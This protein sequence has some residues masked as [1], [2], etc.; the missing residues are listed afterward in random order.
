MTLYELTTLGTFTVITMIFI[1]LG[2]I[3]FGVK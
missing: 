3:L 1:I 2:L